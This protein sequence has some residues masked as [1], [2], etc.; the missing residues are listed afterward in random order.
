MIVESQM[1]LIDDY[2][3]DM[4]SNTKEFNFDISKIISET[5]TE[6]VIEKEK[7]K[8]VSTPFFNEPISIRK[9]I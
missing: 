9:D 6:I 8:P 3:V 1:T 5:D 4:I 7:E 2:Q